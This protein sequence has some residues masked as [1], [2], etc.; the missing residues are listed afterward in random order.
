MLT[1]AGRFAAQP[2]G[3]TAFIPNPLPPEPPVQRDDEMDALLSAADT[4]LGRLDGVASILPDPDLFVAMYVRYEAVLSSQIENTQSTLEDV[5]QF[6][7]DPEADHPRDVEEVVN[8]VSAMNHGL[9]RLTAFPLSLRLIREI[10]AK[11]MQGVRGGNRDP[12]E[13]RRAQNWIGPTGCTLSTAT[14]VPPPVTEMNAALGQFE[15]FLHTEEPIPALIFCAL[16]HA[17]FETIHPFLDGN[18]RIGRLLITFLL[19]QRG[20]LNRPLLYLSHYFKQHRAEYYDRLM[21]VRTDGHWE[22]WTKFFLRGVSEVSLDATATARKILELRETSRAR[23]SR[24]EGTSHLPHRLLDLLFRHPL[25]TIRFVEAELGCSFAKAAQLIEL[26]E[27]PELALV[28]ETTG[29]SRNRRFR[30]KSYLDLFPEARLLPGTE[31]TTPG[32]IYARC[33]ITPSG[34][35]RSIVTILKLSRAKI[36]ELRQDPNNEAFDDR[37]LVSNLFGKQVAGLVYPVPGATYSVGC[38]VYPEGEPPAEIHGRSDER[39][40]DGIT[41]WVIGSNT[42]EEHIELLRRLFDAGGKLVVLNPSEIGF[43]REALVISAQALAKDDLIT[44]DGLTGTLLWRG[45]VTLQITPKGV[46]TAR[47]LPRR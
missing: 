15:N 29:F 45:P 1:R 47:R 40:V 17:Q 16:A 11:L 8:Y 24:L 44:A 43:S 5:L 12:G 20:I 3:Y 25:V 10:H 46:E 7:S 27:R 14:F 9:Q 31:R 35:H 18:G 23:L 39:Q 33:T 2:G 42:G 21:A 32:N 19:C 4:N 28:Q 37:R 22:Q 13:F 36:G 30:F 41:F 34:T 38:T 26:F 6:E